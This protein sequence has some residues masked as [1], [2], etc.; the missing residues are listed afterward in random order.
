M[1]ERRSSPK[2]LDTWYLEGYLENKRNRIWRT[3]IR[4]LPFQVGRRSNCDLSLRSRSVSQNHAEIFERDGQI[5]VVDMGSTNGTFVNG[6]RIQEEHA[7][8]D[9]DILHFAEFEF[10][11]LREVERPAS[12]TIN[13]NTMGLPG[14]GPVKFR[15]LRDMLQE[16]G[17][18][19][20]FQPLVRLA[21]ERIMGYEVLGRGALGGVE[22]SPGELFDIAESI[23]LEVELSVAFR[24]CGARDALRLPDKPLVFLN[25][26]P[27]ELN[28]AGHL[29]RSVEA[30]CTD[31]PALQFVLEIHE[32][33]IT[34]TGPLR[35]LREDLED[36]EVGI[37]FDDFGTGQARLIELVDV[38]PRFLK[39]D[40]IFIR[41]IHQASTMRREMVEKLVRLVL[42]MGVAPVAEGIETEEEAK[43]C[44]MLGFEIAQ[45]YFYGR[46]APV[47]TWLQQPVSVATAR[48]RG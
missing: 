13:L 35:D 6:T 44:R 26:H 46:P 8:V 3:A 9:G 47:D 25:T 39:F 36:L 18:R 14:G 45:G 7:L 28:D 27:A 23:D 42:E 4:T 30:L 29:L 48:S 17:Y 34:G 20:A 32:S 19:A 2:G 41:G 16:G 38:L 11:L 10:H 5:W 1:N 43:S 31:H 33:A 37:A 40:A 22:A 12:H 24:Q 21:D 15:Q